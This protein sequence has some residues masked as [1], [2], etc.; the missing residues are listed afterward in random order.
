MP[1]LEF[2]TG[3]SQVIKI[4]FSPP[5]IIFFLIAGEK[6]VNLLE[7]PPGISFEMNYTKKRKSG[8]VLFWEYYVTSPNLN[9]SS[10][11][12]QTSYLAG[13]FGRAARE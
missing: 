5:L 12:R 7:S 9:T 3:F 8:Q 13:S 1:P 2:L 11:F 10:G 6:E 4:F